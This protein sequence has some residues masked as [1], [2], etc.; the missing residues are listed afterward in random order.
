MATIP[1]ASVN[2]KFQCK[3][4]KL[5]A[6]LKRKDST[7]DH[8]P[9]FFEWLIIYWTWTSSL[10]SSNMPSISCISRIRV[11]QI[12][13]SVKKNKSELT[14]NWTE[15]YSLRLK[16]MNI[17]NVFILPHL[18]HLDWREYF[19]KL[20]YLSK[21][22]K[23]WKSLQQVYLMSQNFLYCLRSNVI[24]SLKNYWNSGEN[25]G[26]NSDQIF[27]WYKLTYLHWCCWHFT[28]LYQYF[29]RSLFTFFHLHRICL[30][31]IDLWAHE[32]E[33]TFQKDCIS[34]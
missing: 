21:T 15:Y 4:F 30:F 31:L 16:K 5:G 19:Y 24:W 22:R 10:S 33:R 18:L 17:S 20:H 3:F 34:C 7:H 9:P 28:C 32:L 6:N 13:F 25:N 23:H 27:C 12:P 11:E 8:R 29:P 2:L 26:N 1:L 14:I